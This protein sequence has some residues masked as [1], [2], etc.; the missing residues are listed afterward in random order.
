MLPDNSAVSKWVA[1]D[2]E[3]TVPVGVVTQEL[4]GFRSRMLQTIYEARKEMENG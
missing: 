1:V 4:D 3:K 2:N